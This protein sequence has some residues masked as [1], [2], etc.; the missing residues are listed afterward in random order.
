ML[1]SMN[2]IYSTNTDDEWV[3]PHP[4]FTL[5]TSVPV[6]K[7]VVL[8]VNDMFIHCVFEVCF[9]NSELGNYCLCVRMLHNRLMSCFLMSSFGF[10][11]FFFSL[12]FYNLFWSLNS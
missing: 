1:Y 10:C 8:E 9:V 2:R 7:C 4:F 12:S 6:W 11:C 5:Y 3:Y